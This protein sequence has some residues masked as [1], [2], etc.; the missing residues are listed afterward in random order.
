MSQEIDEVNVRA[1]QYIIGHQCLIDDTPPL[2]G[3]C[4]W[5][6]AYFLIEDMW[7]LLE[8]ITEPKP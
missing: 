6:D 1:A 3:H 2:R 7:N 8:P 5:C 4:A